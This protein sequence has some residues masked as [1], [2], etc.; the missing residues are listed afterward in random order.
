MLMKDLVLKL[1]EK[2]KSAHPVLY[3]SDAHYGLV[4]IHPF[5]DGN[6][7]TARLLMNL[8]LMSFGYPPAIIPVSRREK[9]LKA[10]EQ[11]QTGQSSMDAFYFIV[12][13]CVERALVQY[14]Q[15]S[16][17]EKKKPI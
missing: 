14:L 15:A 2:S 1:N 12:V 8:I 5:V 11:A 6:G 7:R 3:A 17:Y 13:E 9:Y 16:G 4:Q 10:L